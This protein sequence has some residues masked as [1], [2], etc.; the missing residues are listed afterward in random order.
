MNN[1][2]I[3]IK[4]QTDSLDFVSSDYVMGYGLGEGSTHDQFAKPNNLPDADEDTQMMNVCV[5]DEE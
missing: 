1:K 5:W 2:R 3:Y 4:P